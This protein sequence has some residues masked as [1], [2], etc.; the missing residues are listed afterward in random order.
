MRVFLSFC[1]VSLLLLLSLLLVL[2]VVV[3][4]VVFFCFVCVCVFFLLFFSCC[5]FP[6]FPLFQKK[7]SPA[8]S[9][10]CHKVWIKIRPILGTNSWH[11]LP[12][13]A[14]F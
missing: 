1:V 11:G 9:S 7:N 13:D 6:F 10:E 12:E 14:S 5:Y 8:V 2:V 3:Q 4:V